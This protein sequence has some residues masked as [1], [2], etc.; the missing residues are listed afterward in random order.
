V[1]P[2][3]AVDPRE[4]AERVCAVLRRAGHRALLAGG[5]VRDLLLGTVPKDYDIATSA[6]PEE[7]IPLFPKTRL[8]GV[9]FGVVRVTLGRRVYEVAT[10]R[11]DGPYLDG[12]RPSSV[13]FVGEMQDA[14]RRDFTVNAL[15]MDPETG[16]VLDYVD[17]REDL[18][19]RVIRTVGDPEARF[20]EDHLRLL[21]AVRFASNLRFSIDPDTLA[22]LRRMAELVT[23][24]S[25]ERIR[26]ELIRILTEG[27]AEKG[28]RLLDTS[29]LLDHMLPEVAAMRGVE[30]PPAFHP[31]GDVF[32]HTVRMLGLMGKAPVALALGVLLHDIGKP[33]TMTVEDRIRF[34]RHASEGA[35]TA[36]RVC[37]RLRMPGATTRRVVWLVGQH[38]RL[39]DVPSMRESKRVRFVREP[40]FRLLLELGRLDCLASHGDLATIRWIQ[41]YLKNLGSGIEAPPPLLTGND[42][43]TLGLKPGPLFGE[44]LETVEDARLEG[45][46]ATPDEARE[47]VLGLWPLPDGPHTSASS[48]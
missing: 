34:S 6:L 41:D 23:R 18:A 20:S 8:V 30:Q 22:A 4:G 35:E 37:R 14:L 47:M 39:S 36:G 21:R 10:F 17:G 29:G 25:A 15:F 24:T 3:F 26:E 44:I 7:I 32:E 46:I 48:S 16:E 28:F 27:N 11:Q 19:R 38:M 43:I 1:K 12:R 5:C 45:L 13:A 40:D 2:P 31:E 33:A 9:A 42:L